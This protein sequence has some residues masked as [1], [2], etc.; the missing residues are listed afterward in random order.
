[1]EVTVAIIET[2]GNVIGSVAWAWAVVNV[3]GII[4]KTVLVAEYDVEPERLKEMIKRCQGY[5]EIVES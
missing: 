4:S 5:F 1:M 3:A 2:F